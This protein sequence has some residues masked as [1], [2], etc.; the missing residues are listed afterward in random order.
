LLRSRS[1]FG[2]SEYALHA[3]ATQANCTWIAD[4]IDANTAQTLASRAYRAANRVCVGQARRVRFRSS[5]R[6]LPSLEGKINK[7]GIRFVLQQPPAGKGGWL[8]WGQDRLAAVIEWNDPVVHHGLRQR[9]KYAR[10]LRRKASS[11]RANGTD[12]DGY[13]YYAQLALEGTPYQKPTHPVGQGTVGLDLGPST[14]AIVPQQGQARLETFCAEVIPNARAKRRLQRKLDRQ[15]RANNPHNYDAQ[16]RCKK[17]RKT[18]HD[19]Q[20]YKTTR[21][22]L[23]HQERKLAAQRKS[24]HGQL[25][26]VVVAAG[27]TIITE[28]LSYRAWQRQFG[29]SVGLRAPG[30]FI[31]RLRRTVASTG[32][33]LV[34]VPTVRT[35]LSQYCH[36]CG[37]YLKKPLSQ[38][39]HACPCGIGPVQRDLYSALL[40]AHLQSQDLCSLCCPANLGECGD[41]LAGSNRGAHPT[42]ECG[43]GRAP[44][45]RHHRRKTCVFLKVLETS[46]KSAVSPLGTAM[47]GSA[48]KN[49]PAFRR[50]SLRDRSP[51]HARQPHSARPR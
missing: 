10:L 51:G 42:R 32:G 47:S 34:E 33:T 25:A 4:H 26:H 5:G 17:G 23:A 39:W 50:E 45:L 2:F 27:K 16:G 22:R 48:T 12:R 36:G 37:T 41:A 29:R 46:R 21:R 8:V 35:K 40:A 3:F 1:E 9:I 30:M 6:G 49:L 43:A 13:R 18:W 24:L 20:G 44:K 28:Q 14:I 15:R 11:P 31:E 7:Q 19:S 38:R